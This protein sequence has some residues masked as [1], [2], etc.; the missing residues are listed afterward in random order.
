MMQTTDEKRRSALARRD[1]DLQLHLRLAHEGCDEEIRAWHDRKAQASLRDVNN[2][3]R[4][5]GM[6][7][8][9]A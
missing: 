1:G 5:L 7:E 8:V 9:L 3:R 2:I 4:K 6:D